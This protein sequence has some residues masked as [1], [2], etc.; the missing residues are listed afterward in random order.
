MAQPTS[1][2]ITIPISEGI[3]SNAS[4]LDIGPKLL[5]AENAVWGYRYPVVDGGLNPVIYPPH[6][7]RVPITFPARYPITYGSNPNKFVDIGFTNHDSDDR[8]KLLVGT[9]TTGNNLRLWEAETGTIIGLAGGVTGQTLSSTTPGPGCSAYWPYAGNAVDNTNIT[10]AAFF[11]SHP[12]VNEIFYLLDSDISANA[13]RSMNDDPITNTPAGA[14]ALAVHLDRL[15]MATGI[16]TASK[17]WFTDPFDAETIRAESFVN[18]GDTVRAM[19]PTVPGDID[20]TGQAHLFVGCANSI[21]C[22]DG[23]PTSNSALRRQVAAGI[24]V[25]GPLAAC[26]SPYGVFFVGT[27]YQIHLMPPDGRQIID[28]AY[29]IADKIGYQPGGSVNTPYTSLCWFPPYLYYFAAGR[30][31]ECYIGDMTNPSKPTWW[32]P[33]SSDIAATNSIVKGISDGASYNTPLG[34]ASPAVYAAAPLTSTTGYFTGFDRYTLAQGSY[35]LGHEAGRIQSIT[36]GLI[37]RPGYR[38]YIDSVTLETVVKAA[39]YTWQVFAVNELA[40]SKQLHRT[41]T[42]AIPTSGTRDSNNIAKHFYSPLGAAGG[43]AGEKVRITIV[44]DTDVGTESKSMDLV[45]VR[46]A[47]RYIPLGNNT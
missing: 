18:I 1:E 35:P 3:F 15:W 19:L 2:T 8:K 22:V 30:P 44:G 14:T 45:R 5:R 10:G 47:V 9:T 39:D 31:D 33:I 40:Q 16:T 23:D 17:I 21:W 26:H 13:I 11:F 46:V 36:T 38:V 42:K 29:P 41:V 32:G 6:L 7:L 27:D 43:A 4:A 34:N 28:I 12:L 20:A 24:G 25:P 37:N